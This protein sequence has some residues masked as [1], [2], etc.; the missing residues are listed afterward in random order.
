V[1]Y[2]RAALGIVYERLAEEH[3]MDALRSVVHDLEAAMIP[4]GQVNQARLKAGR[5]ITAGSR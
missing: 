4:P 1:T 2:L 5:A 3:G